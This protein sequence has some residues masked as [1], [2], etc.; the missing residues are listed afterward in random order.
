MQYIAP[1]LPAANKRHVFCHKAHYKHCVKRLLCFVRH[2][3]GSQRY[4]SSLVREEWTL[5]LCMARRCDNKRHQSS[6]LQSCAMRTFAHKLAS[7]FTQVWLIP[8]ADCRR[9]SVRHVATNNFYWASRPGYHISLTQP[10]S[11]ALA[12]HAIPYWHV[13][14]TPCP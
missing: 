3:L 9:K 7:R 1:V 8:L 14:H 11:A 13:Q 4:N 2:A 12:G 6:M 5:K 10:R